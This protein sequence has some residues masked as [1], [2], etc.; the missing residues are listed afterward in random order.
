MKRGVGTF[1]LMVALAAGSRLAVTPAPPPTAASSSSMHGVPPEGRQSG[2]TICPAFAEQ[3]IGKAS[4]S[5]GE[6][7]VLVRQFLRGATEQ[8]KSESDLLP[9]DI[10]I[11][12]AT[13]PDPLHTLLN[14][15]FDR[16]IDAIQQAAQ[17]QGY[18]YDSSWLPWKAEAAEYS[19]LSDQIA[20][21]ED[22]SQRELCPGL[23][24]FRQSMHR[25]TAQRYDDT[26]T[27]GLF[28]F[29]VAE[30]PTTG[31]NR[32]QWDNALK[33]IQEHVDK[34]NAD[35]ALRVLGP[36][37]SG[38]VP[39]VA[40]ALVD[41]GGQAGNFSNVLLYTGTIHGCS[42]VRW[43]Q[44]E[45][46]KWDPVPVHVADFRENDT[47]QI[48]R[49]FRYLHD[50]G[51]SV[52]EV[53]ILSEDETAYGG[54]AAGDAKPAADDAKPAVVVAK[55][56]AGDA[57]PAADDAK[58]A[59]A[60]APSYPPGEAPLHLYY[61]RDISSLRSA[62]QEQSIFASPTADRSNTAHVVLQPQ[63]TRSTHH[64][65]DTGATFSGPNMSLQQ[66]AQMYGIIDT[67]KTHGIR[68]V[69]LRSTSSLDYLFLARFLHRA[70]PDAFIV[71]MGADMLFG[72]EIDSTEFRG[73][74]ALTPFPLLPRGQDWTRRSNKLARH[75]HRVFGS[76]TMEGTYLATR[77]LITDLDPSNPP[78]FIDPMKADIADYRAPFWEQK[79]TATTP[80]TW[81]SVIGRDG[82]WPVAVLTRTLSTPSPDS[83]VEPVTL[84][85][86][87]DSP[88]AAHPA[89]WRFSLSPA[90]KFCCGL[91]ALAVCLHFYACLFGWRR[92]DQGMF[93]QFA[94]LPAK[95]QFFLIGLGWATIGS[96][97]I[98]ML[99]CS[100]KIGDYLE[101]SNSLWISVL[102]VVA[103]LA[104]L[105][106]VL[107]ILLRS[108][109]EPRSARIR[110]LREWMRRLRAGRSQAGSDYK[111]APYAIVFIA[112]PI[113]LLVGAY[114]VGTRLFAGPNGI[115]TAYRA[116]HLTN[117]VSPMVSLLLLLSAFY[118]WFW[119]TLSGLALLG[120]GRPILPR[121]KNLPPILA[122]ISS[123][124]AG[125]IESRAMPLPDLRRGWVYLFPIAILAPPLYALWHEGPAGFDPIF[126]SLENHA[127]NQTLHALLALALYLLI[128]E[129]TQLLGTW[130]SLKRLL[131]AL[132]RLPLRRTFSA[133]QG[134][135]MRSLWS[136]SGASSRA[137][138]TIFSH[139]LES[140][141]H[142]RN[143]LRSFAFRDCGDELIRASIESAC[144]YGSKFVEDRSQAADLAMINDREGRH[145]REE[146]CQCTEHIL[147]DLIL[148]EWLNETRSMDL[149]EGGG[150]SDSNVV[151]P[152]SEDEP[153]RL[154][155][156]FVCLTYVGYLQNL[157]ARMRTMVLS[158]VG[159]LAG[160][161]FSLA[162]YPYVPRPTIAISILL[163]V[164]VVGSAVAL[165]YAGLERD[166]TL[167]RITNT[168]PGKLGLG[169]WLRYGS[170]IGVPILGLLAAQFPAIT[171]FVTSWIEPSLNAAK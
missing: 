55:S 161:A 80:S 54:L 5:P 133:L 89:R 154:A 152:L 86:E 165:V 33:W 116:V 60:C 142:L 160:F 46:Q 85:G 4:A 104:C 98:L 105:G 20:E 147:S 100:S 23:I 56:A 108:F 44:E 93:I 124:M 129:C 51:H 164:L 64:D 32:A 159:V 106:I 48:D 92:E 115:P 128:L 6:L 3:Q 157:L 121:E 148:P 15:Q 72:R 42:S 87:S 30:K 29:L 169:F 8:S 103:W 70:Y 130:L 53:A 47:I 71:T 35:R 28:V 90:W 62:Y 127:F 123:E 50:R 39:S 75:A 63:A 2:A 91:A 126:H 132:N 107:D 141:V 120:G 26:Y 59:P 117:G 145:M 10:H 18:T 94:P 153:T 114:W 119:H 168:E 9:K 43:L 22:T 37:F 65:T 143:V 166:S 162:F 81:L 109:G 19:S 137:R 111:R 163:L 67:L 79:S 78:G 25:S 101:K 131:L 156:E 83:T 122:R 21:N 97:A 52:S 149:M 158:I 69:V 146:F 24:L 38:S 66:E 135:S 167:S 57:K 14:L 68:F 40:R 110:S 77:F 118:W 34:K 17:D 151:L 61:P 84:P 74:E 99:Q 88:T 155:E 41:S 49:Y 13:V 102:Y 112:F 11:L 125:D 27:H 138:Y 134:L 45:L 73:V 1:I 7:A 58:P 12:V 150:K 95:R 76:D 139:Q 140:L 82:Y 31:I 136:L 113:V 16:T 144:T 96:I 170:F 36:N 171:D